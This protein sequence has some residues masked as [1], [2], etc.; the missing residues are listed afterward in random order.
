MR[1]TIL[2]VL[3]VALLLTASVSAQSWQVDLA[4][5]S[6]GFSVSHLVISKTTGTFN[7]F[8]GKVNFDGENLSKGS[9]EFTIKVASLDTDDE[10][11]DGHLKTADFFDVEKYPNM[12][13]KSKSITD[14]QDGKFKI[15]GELTIKDVTKEVTF[16]CEYRG[17]VKD[18]WGGTRAGFSAGTTINRQDFNI[19]F[20]KLLEAGG[21]MVGN[22]VAISLEIELVQS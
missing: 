19:A 14:A 18:P 4:H 9:V 1:K 15:T 21:L 3:A 10:K 2:S 22:D 16:D 12:A 7:E 13:F 11:R 5:S 6:V 20:S 17:T 8:E